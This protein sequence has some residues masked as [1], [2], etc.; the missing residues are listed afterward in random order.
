MDKKNM[1][2]RLLWGMPLWCSLIIIPGFF[3][4]ISDDPFWL[5]SVLLPLTC[6]IAFYRTERKA[7]IF[8]ISFSVLL[9]LAGILLPLLA[10]VIGGRKDTPKGELKRLAGAVE[11]Y[12]SEYGVYPRQA[13]LRSVFEWR[14]HFNPHRFVDPWGNEYKYELST[15]QDSFR[16][17][18]LGPDG[19][20]GTED[21]I[22]EERPPEK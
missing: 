10:G 6:G 3:L 14:R 2:R 11:Q 4:P 12:K 19:I 1:K 7:A 17:Y 22:T 20:E 5:V 13:D 9:L 21:D 18:S 16:V 15:S 8:S